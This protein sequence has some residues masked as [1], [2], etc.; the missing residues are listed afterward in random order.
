MD[1]EHAMTHILLKNLL[2]EAEMNSDVDRIRNDCASAIHFYSGY[3]GLF[4]GERGLP[5][6]MDIF[7]RDPSKHDRVSANTANYYTTLVKGSSAWKEAGI[8]LRH[9]SIIMTTS[10]P[11][12]S[13]YGV[14]YVVFPI[15][16]AKLAYGSELD[17]WD[18]HEK[19]SQNA[20]GEGVTLNVDEFN[21]RFIDNIFMYITGRSYRDVKNYAKLEEL[22]QYADREIQ[23][24]PEIVDLMDIPSYT[25]NALRTIGLIGIINKY[26]DP[27]ANGIRAVSIDTVRTID[28]R[29]VWTD[30]PCWFVRADQR[31]VFE[32]LGIRDVAR[33]FKDL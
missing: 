30:S 10:E 20:F 22:I 31:Q 28:Y 17:N 27:V 8:P 32:K 29:E 19:G 26:I 9:S 7:Y 12:A 21:E 23:T 16:G 5:D 3:A 6:H 25:R 2:R 4:R 13:S 24:K 1:T 11:V 15:D 14:P 33:H 18:N